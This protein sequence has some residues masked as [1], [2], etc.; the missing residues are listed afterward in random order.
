VYALDTPRDLKAGA[1]KKKLV[2]AMKGHILEEGTL[3]G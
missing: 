3:M 2:A 1:T